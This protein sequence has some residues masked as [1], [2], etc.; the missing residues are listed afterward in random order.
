MRG[1]A[2]RLDRDARKVE[3]GREYAFG[4]Q[5]RQRRFDPRFKMPKN[6]HYVRRLA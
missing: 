2:R 5:R 3:T 1:I 6:I 4:H